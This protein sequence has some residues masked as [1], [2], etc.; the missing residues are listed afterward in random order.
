MRI[1]M[2]VV[3]SSG[4]DSFIGDVQDA[5]IDRCDARRRGSN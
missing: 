4:T 3:Q 1:E 2:G 5:L